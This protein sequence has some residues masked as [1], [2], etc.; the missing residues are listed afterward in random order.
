[1]TVVANIAGVEAEAEVDV[2]GGD[3]EMIDEEVEEDAEEMNN[4]LDT[5]EEETP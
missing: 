2:I 3:P 1:M 4:N 5:T